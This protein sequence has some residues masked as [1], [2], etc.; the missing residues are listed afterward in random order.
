[1]FLSFQTMSK[2]ETALKSLA[3][4]TRQICSSLHIASLQDRQLEAVS[5]HQGRGW[6]ST[7]SFKFIGCLE[8]LSQGKR[9]LP[10]EA[11]EH[12]RFLHHTGG[13][14]FG[15]MNTYQKFIILKERWNRGKKKK[16]NN[17]E[18][19][20]KHLGGR[21]CAAQQDTQKKTYRK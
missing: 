1:M 17:M 5:G 14:T 3:P 11:H 20:K 18:A 9:Q 4:P 19:A 15:M 8:F 21:H 10:K 7:Y 6:H 13:T 12:I 16:K 2:Y